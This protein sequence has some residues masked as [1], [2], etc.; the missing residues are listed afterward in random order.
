M[1]LDQEHLYVQE[2]VY[3]AVIKMPAAEFQRV[4]KCRVGA[5]TATCCSHVATILYSLG[6]LSHMPDAFR[7]RHLRY[8]YYDKANPQ[9][10]NQ[11]LL[12]ALFH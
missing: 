6:I 5:R 8:N 11:D 4:G 10:M 7:T 1:N 3:A 12:A 2:T 9:A